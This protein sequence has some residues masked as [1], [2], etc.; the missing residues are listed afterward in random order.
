MSLVIG[1]YVLLIDCFGMNFDM[2]FQVDFPGKYKIALLAC[3][4]LLLMTIH[5]CCEF[6]NIFK[7]QLA[8]WSFIFRFIICMSP[9]YMLLLVRN[10]IES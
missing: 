2:H 10:T 4:F 5:M 8:S 1:I 9:S 6:M 3:I 7:F